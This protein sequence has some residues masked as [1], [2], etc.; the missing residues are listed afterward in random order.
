MVLPELLGGVLAGNTLENLLATGVVILELGQI[1]NV[2]IDNDVQV[3]GLVV[4][5][6]VA[7]GESLRHA[8]GLDVACVEEGREWI[9]EIRGI[10]GKGMKKEMRKKNRKKE[11]KEIISRRV[12]S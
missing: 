7:D 8:D 5:R 6:H 12:R 11:K 10:M 1:I 3:I 2:A 4:R 9:N